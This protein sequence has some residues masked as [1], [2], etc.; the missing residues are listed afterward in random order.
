MALGKGFQGV[1]LAENSNWLIERADQ[2]LARLMINGGLPANGTVHQRQ[3]RG[4]DLDIGQ[5]A[6]VGGCRES[7]EVAHDPSPQGHDTATPLH[8]EG[9][10]FVKNTAELSHGLASLT[11]GHRK[12]NGIEPGAFERFHGVWAQDWCHVAVG[13]DDRFFS[14]KTLPRERPKSAEDSFPNRDRITSL[15]EVDPNSPHS[16]ITA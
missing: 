7:G 1:H 15:P 5:P 12:Q 16:A 6:K 14:R 10:Q 4:R 11:C 13:D 2:V 9:G 3:Q 8:T